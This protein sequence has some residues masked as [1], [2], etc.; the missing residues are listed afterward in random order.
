MSIEKH[1][2][3][4]KYEISLNGD[5]IL[6]CEGPR[7]WPPDD[8]CVEM[9]FDAAEERLSNAGLN[10]EQIEAQIELMH[11]MRVVLGRVPTVDKTES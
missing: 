2:Y 5:I 11:I 4:D 7:I 1:E 8:E 10:D 3:G 9:L 6:S